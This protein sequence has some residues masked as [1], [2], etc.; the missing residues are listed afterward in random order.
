MSDTN[1]VRN[2]EAGGRTVTIPVRPDLPSLSQEYEAQYV[3]LLD[4]AARGN[5]QPRYLAVFWPMIGHRYAGELMII[6]RAVNGW[7]IRWLIGDDRSTAAVAATARRHSKRDGDTDPLAWV[8]AS[9]GGRADGYNSNRS[10]FWQ[11]PRHLL[12]LER[13]GELSD[14]TSGL[15]WSN[16]AKLAPEPG[17]NPRG[18]LFDLQVQ[19]GPDLIRQE[20][21]ELRPERVL[22]MTGRGWFEPFARRLEIDVRWL[23][24][25]NLAVEGAGAG[26]G[27]KWVVTPHPMTRSPGLLAQSALDA[28]RSL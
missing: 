27:A 26:V 5:V 11:T 28:F 3:R 20:V 2:L 24:G 19:Y 21:R 25:R 17:G 7:M 4:R 14:W 6:G 9:A 23:D 22:V 13:G 1:R 18:E 15:A 16:L 10:A 8:P 12:R